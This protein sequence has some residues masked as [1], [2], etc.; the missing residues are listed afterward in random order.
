VKKPFFGHSTRAEYG[1][2]VLLPGPVKAFGGMTGIRALRWGHG[3]GYV[4]VGL[5]LGGLLGPRL[6]PFARGYSIISR[7]SVVFPTCHT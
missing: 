6:T 7:I 2:R 3:Q 5:L 1:Y 4:A